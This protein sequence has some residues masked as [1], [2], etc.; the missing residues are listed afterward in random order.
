MY[1]ERERESLRTIAGEKLRRHIRD[2]ERQGHGARP[3]AWSGIVSTM[4]NSKLEA[5]EVPLCGVPIKAPHV[6]DRAPMGW[7][8]LKWTQLRGP[9]FN[10]LYRA[11]LKM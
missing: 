7:T 9:N 5:D 1:I 11:L 4:S 3:R 8:Q 2:E 10:Q 6:L